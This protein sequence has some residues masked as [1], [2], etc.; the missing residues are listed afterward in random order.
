[1]VYFIKKKGKKIKK[2][3]RD[4]EKHRHKY[5]STISKKCQNKLK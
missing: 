5:R 3:K 2:I 1:M 4:V